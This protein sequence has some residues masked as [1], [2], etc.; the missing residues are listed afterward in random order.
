MVIGGGENQ[1][2]FPVQWGLGYAVD[3]DRKKVNQL[4]SIL[5]N[6]DIIK[7]KKVIVIISG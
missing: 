7:C 3:N 1:S 5:S 6:R 4:H 2:R